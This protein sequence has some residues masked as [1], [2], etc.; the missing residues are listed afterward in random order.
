MTRYGSVPDEEDA[1]ADDHLDLVLYFG[2]QET[3]IECGDTVAQLT[4]EARLGESFN[5]TVVIEKTA[6]SK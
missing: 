4:G 3:G 1:N 2:T 5:S 6:T